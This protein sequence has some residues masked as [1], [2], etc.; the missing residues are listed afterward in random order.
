MYSE[1]QYRLNKIVDLMIKDVQIML[2]ILI[3][4]SHKNVKDHES[5]INQYIQFM[6][7]KLVKAAEQMIADDPEELYKLN[8]SSV[9]YYLPLDTMQ[10]LF[11]KI[12]LEK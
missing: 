2:E 11:D 3:E 1:M 5:E 12:F 8:F 7:P 6:R 10:C 4:D 9:R